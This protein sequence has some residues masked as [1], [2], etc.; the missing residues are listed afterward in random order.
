MIR[1]GFILVLVISGSI[2]LH[3]GKISFAQQPSEQ[4]VVQVDGAGCPF[5]V[6]GIEKWFIKID[7]VEDVAM[8]LETGKATLTLK[9]GAQ[10]TEEMVE[11][12]VKKAGFTP[13]AI[14]GI[15][16]KKEPE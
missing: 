14:Q 12:A 5:C 2:F 3:K 16:Y 6:F 10:V 13:S 8:D 4:I 15:T 7:G 9:P 11:H 1:Y